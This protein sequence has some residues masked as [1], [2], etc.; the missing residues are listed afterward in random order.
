MTLSFDLMPDGS[1]ASRG[2]GNVNT[3]QWYSIQYWVKPLTGWNNDFVYLNGTP[4]LIRV[5]KQRL[6]L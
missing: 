6:V 5:S 3:Y 2:E 1:V 4:K